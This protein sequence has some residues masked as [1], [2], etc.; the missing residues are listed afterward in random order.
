MAPSAAGSDHNH[1]STGRDVE[2]TS[3]QQ[4]RG[5]IMFVFKACFIFAG[6]HLPHT[7]KCEL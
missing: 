3:P 5:Q 4:G 1:G 6:L 7:F 2:R